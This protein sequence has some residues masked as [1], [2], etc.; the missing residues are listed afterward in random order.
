M[1]TPRWGRDPSCLGPTLVWREGAPDTP[2][3][4]VLSSVAANSLEGEELDILDAGSGSS[5]DEVTKLFHQS[6][7]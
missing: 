5:G 7:L 2:L 3:P 4:M 6:R 1:A